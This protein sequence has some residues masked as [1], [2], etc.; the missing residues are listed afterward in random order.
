M[1]ENEHHNQMKN[2]MSFAN[3]YT[4]PRSVVKDK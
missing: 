3:G 4:K 2:Q 1:K